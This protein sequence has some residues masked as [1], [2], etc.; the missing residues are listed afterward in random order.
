MSQENVEVVRRQNELFSKGDLDRWADY[1][2]PEVV[3]TQPRLMPLE[4]LRRRFVM[5][6]RVLPL[7]HALGNFGT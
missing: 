4:L 3:V 7:A 5:R 6:A 1:W 2:D